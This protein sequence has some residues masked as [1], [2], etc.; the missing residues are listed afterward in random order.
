MAK[1]FAPQSDPDWQ[2]DYDTE[3]FQ[4]VWVGPTQVGAI[5]F[6]GI[7]DAIATPGDGQHLFGTAGLGG[8]VTAEAAGVEA[9]GVSVGAHNGAP[10]SDTNAATSVN[11]GLLGI[12]S[13]QSDIA[14]FAFPNPETVTLTGSGMVFVNTYG[15]GVNDAF[16]TAIIYAENELQSHFTNAVTLRVSFDFGDAHGFLAYN[17]F[18]NTVRPNYATLT[19]A[20]STHATTADDIAAVNAFPATV[21]SNAH[22][23]SSTTGFLVAAGMARILGLAGPSGT[24]LTKES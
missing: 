15:A 6:H 19:N 1:K 18:F 5:S 8:S 11:T 12:D 7:V 3:E 20:L 23:S 24:R 9:A 17:S 2:V 10:Q 21:P 4:S 16:H 13:P 14:T 22:S